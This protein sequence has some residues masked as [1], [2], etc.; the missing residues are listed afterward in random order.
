M[1]RCASLRRAVTPDIFILFVVFIVFNGD[2]WGSDSLQFK[3]EMMMLRTSLSS[4]SSVIPSAPLP[5]RRTS[6][7][8][9]VFVNS[10]SSGG[11]RYEKSF[12]SS[13]ASGVRGVAANSFPRD[14]DDDVEEVV[15]TVAP[16]DSLYGVAIAYDVDPR[17]LIAANVKTLGGFE[18]VLPG[19]RL[20]VPGQRRGGGIGGGGQQR[21]QHQSR[22]TGMKNLA[23]NNN[24]NNISSSVV[25]GQQHGGGVGAMTK[26]TAAVARMPTIV[27]AVS[28]VFGL[29]FGLF[30]FSRERE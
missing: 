27:T 21:Q 28:F 11:D 17:D 9:S 14:D 18:Y 26:T 4:S 25:V 2:F 1:D 15:H 6:K 30:L 22:M 29:A 20:V 7:S 10:T 19:Q 8:R 5:R 23:P 3:E 16:G 12:P 13:S 24:G